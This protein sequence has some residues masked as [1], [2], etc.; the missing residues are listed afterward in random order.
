MTLWVSICFAQSQRAFFGLGSNGATIGYEQ[1]FLPQFRVGA[2]TNFLHLNGTLVNYVLDNWIKTDYKTSSLQIE[3]FVKWYP[4][5][6][7][8][9][10]Y[11]KAGLALRLNPSY[12]ANSTFMDKTMIGSFE[13]NKDQAGYV[14]IDIRTNRIQPMLAAGYSIIDKKKFFLN[15]EAGVYFHGTPEVN[16]EATGTL[17]LNTVNQK[18]IQDKIYKYKYFPV[19]K[20]EAGIKL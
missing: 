1:S 10:L 19:L 13:L 18:A 7:A 11:T 9:R 17:H 12:V 4:Q 14:N 6:K 5:K 15:T 16:M 3:G 8:Q 20:I 2:A